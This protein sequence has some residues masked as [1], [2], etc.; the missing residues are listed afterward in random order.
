MANVGIIIIEAIASIHPMNSAQAG[1]GMLLY[2]MP[3]HWAKLAR[4]ITYREGQMI[5]NIT[6]PVMTEIMWEINETY[7]SSDW[8]YVF[9]TNEKKDIWALA[10]HLFNHVT[11]C[12][13]A[14]NDKKAKVIHS[15]DASGWVQN[16]TKYN[17]N[18]RAIYLGDIRDRKW[19]LHYLQHSPVHLSLHYI[20]LYRDNDNNE[21]IA[22][23]DIILMYY[24]IKK[25]LAM[26]T[27]WHWNSHGQLLSTTSLSY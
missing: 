9:P 14:W 2:D 13:S 5:V 22:T 11:K 27:L 19:L 6:A 17:F 12:L 1:Y 7:Q 25:D 21:M 16:T 8:R 3:A 4:M 15:R 20:P 26:K 10:N 24:Q 18:T 23:R